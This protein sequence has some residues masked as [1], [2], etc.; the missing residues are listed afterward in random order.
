MPDLHSVDEH[1]VENTD[2]RERAIGAVL[3]VLGLALAGGALMKIPREHVQVAQ[4]DT[5][6]PASAQPRPDASNPSRAPGEAEPGGVRPTTPA[7]EPARPQA[8]PGQTT[9]SAPL[10]TQER[11]PQTGQPLPPA[12]AEK[13]APPLDTK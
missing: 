12:P 8:A 11:P 7:P 9:G 4:A 13:V 3:L 6:R 1:K 5:D 10:T 2:R